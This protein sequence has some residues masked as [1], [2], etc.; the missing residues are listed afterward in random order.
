MNLRKLV[1]WLLVAPMILLA[2][3]FVME[4]VSRLPVLIAIGTIAAV[5]GAHLLG[6]IN[7]LED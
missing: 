1:G 6:W 4:A 3:S 2:A 7:I 5:V